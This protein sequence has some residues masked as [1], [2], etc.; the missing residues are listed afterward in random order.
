MNQFLISIPEEQFWAKFQ[1]IID[2]RIN[3]ILQENKPTNPETFSINKVSRM[4]KRKHSTVKDLVMSGA[5]KSTD[6]GRITQAAIND[7]LKE[8]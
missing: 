3:Q 8:T 5:I 2:S 4:L 1:S 6:D 7:Y